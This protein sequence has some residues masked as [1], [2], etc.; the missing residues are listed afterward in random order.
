MTLNDVLTKQNAITKL[1]FKEGDKELSKQLKV[2][3]MRI[4]MAYSK[5][6]NQFNEESKEFVKQLIPAELTL[7]SNKENKSEEELC[8]FNELNAKINSEYQEYL[9]QKGLESYELT[10]EDKFN[11]D[12]YS[13]IIDINSGN[14]V[15]INGNK[16]RA[17]D[18][19]EVIYDLFVKE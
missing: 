6:T 12:E 5:I 18:F 17:V 9:V 2:K 13:D 3:I 16:I 14:D 19:L 11:L 10:I 8:R 7:L 4:R 1:N 15:I